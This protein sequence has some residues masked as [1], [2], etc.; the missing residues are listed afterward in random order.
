MPPSLAQTLTFLHV[1]SQ[2]PTATA[3]G[4]VYSRVVHQVGSHRRLL[5]VCPPDS[6]ATG[7]GRT[8]NMVRTRASP[9]SDAAAACEL[10]R[11]SGEKRV[12]RPRTQRDR[13]R[14]NANHRLLLVAA[15]CQLPTAARWATDRPP[16]PPPWEGLPLRRRRIRWI[17]PGFIAG[18][19]L[20]GM[21]DML[22]ARGSVCQACRSGVAI[23]GRSRAAWQLRNRGNSGSLP[24]PDSSSGWLCRLA[25][26]FSRPSVLSSTHCR[27]CAVRLDPREFLSPV[28]MA[29]LHCAFL[30]PL[31]W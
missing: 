2:E 17:S 3:L 5:S 28:S 25:L 24:S 8:V 27:I 15:R 10:C 29:S 14:Q 12:P 30:P 6:R 13:S 19:F 16:P 31:F 4:S 26:P 18:S 11:D 21:S 20:I 23:S 7:R 1:S 22:G 9:G